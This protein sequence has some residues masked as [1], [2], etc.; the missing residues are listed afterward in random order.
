M[1]ISNA[2]I[3]L[4][5][6]RR[7]NVSFFLTGR[8]G[9]GK[10]TL[11]QQIIKES[12]KNMVVLAPTGI[13]AL[14]VNGMT[15]HSFFG[16]PSR[17]L[18]IRDEAVKAFWSNSEKRKL[19]ESLDTVIIDE[20]SMVRADLMDAIDYSLR[21]NSNNPQLPFGGKQMIFVG[22]LFQLEPIVS[23]EKEQRYIKQFY[24]SAHFFQ[25]KAF[26]D[27]KF[28]TIELDQV[29]RQR[30]ENFVKLLDRIRTGVFDHNDLQIL[31]TRVRKPIEGVL[32]LTT[33]VDIA[34]EINKKEFLALDG[35]SHSFQAIVKGNFQT[36]VNPAD[37]TLDLKIGSQIIFIKNDKEGRWVNG[38]LGRVHYLTEN[39]I[40][41][42]LTNGNIYQ[43]DRE[44]WDN[45]KYSFN[46][47]TNRVEAQRIGTYKQFP[48]KPAWA[49]TIHKS[50]G[51]TFSKLIIDFGTGTFAN[52][53]AYVA[54]SRVQSL[55]GLFLKRSVKAEDI[56]V[57]LSLNSVSDQFSS[58]EL[59]VEL[60]AAKKEYS[61]LE[62]R[63]FIERGNYY[64]YD[65]LKSVIR[66]DWGGAY[67]KFFKA[68]GILTSDDFIIQNEKFLELQSQA[69]ETIRLMDAVN[70]HNFSFVCGVISFLNND[71]EKAVNSFKRI[72]KY[73]EGL[74]QYFLSKSLLLNQSPY[75]SLEAIDR[76]LEI[77]PSSRGYYQKAMIFNPYEQYHS[78]EQLIS[79][80]LYI[81]NLLFSL[82]SNISNYSSYRALL[83]YIQHEDLALDLPDESVYL[84]EIKK[85]KIDA[86]FFEK[87]R[88]K[89]QKNKPKL[90]NLTFSVDEIQEMEK[91]E[92][93]ELFEEYEISEQ[94]LME[95]GLDEYF[96][97]GY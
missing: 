97:D 17:M 59:L 56:M 78:E 63:N 93:E 70:D 8:A 12:D 29:F 32:A 5:F 1:K 31:N 72:S 67:F 42:E 38:T 33:R 57:D 90:L 45:V 58:K 88:R 13:A 10:S 20:V 46:S 43:V 6:A 15:I 2:N 77:V 73:E 28:I 41:V 36:A 39:S 44:V 86:E 81:E 25:A 64:L 91:V 34:N 35:Q 61:L 60:T 48:L 65:A 82:N 74:V 80:D 27:F 9:T 21:I 23:K 62:S 76:S 83:N 11:L 94:D 51:M 71:F 40:Q 24:Q 7:T 69:L 22:D 55:D 85:S 16:L 96:D 53:Q 75:Q 79:R 19:I 89:L 37:Q 4:E 47:V 84:S 92:E 18:L 66:S 3:A 26:N 68:F 49:I 87:M 95:D 50:Q 54:L 14:N 52:G 30:D